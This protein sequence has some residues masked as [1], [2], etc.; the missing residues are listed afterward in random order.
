[1]PARTAVLKLLASQAAISLENAA[2]YSNLRHSEAYLAEAQRLSQTGSFGWNVSSGKIVWSPK[3]S[4][5][6][7][8][9]RWLPPPLRWLCAMF[10]QKILLAFKGQSNACHKTE[11]T[12]RTTTDC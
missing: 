5:F 7:D 6:S 10:T 8:T 2:L 11:M 1:A 3:C 12:V 4:A 9:T